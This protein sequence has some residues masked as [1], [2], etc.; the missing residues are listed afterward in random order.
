MKRLY[1]VAVLLLFLSGFIVSCGGDDHAIIYPQFYTGVEGT[2]LSWTDNSDASHSFT[3]VRVDG[4]TGDVTTIGGFGF[5]PAMAYAPDGTL[6]G[7]SDELRIIDPVDGST[8]RIGDLQ[9]PGG[10]PILMHGAAF[11]PS[12][13]LYVV[14]NAM[15]SRVFTVDL[16]TAELTY[17]G[18]PSALIWDIQFASNG[19]SYGAFAD[20][21]ILNPVDMSTVSDV[22]PIGSEG[23]YVLPLTFD[24]RGQLFGMDIYPSTR[25]S[26]I[27]LSTGQAFSVINTG[28]EGLNSLV[29]E[30][31]PSVAAGVVFSKAAETHGYSSPKPL[32]ALLKS[33]D[34]IKSARKRYL[35]NKP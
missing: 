10:I 26:F 11:S 31:T 5:F 22:G 3:L 19:M 25:I 27:N 32:D 33:A 18:T 16:A 21:F 28:S 15:P 20:L 9:L 8:V 24:S 17:V 29:V 13:V 30:R 35:E 7:I 34:E 4:K 14:E 6:Y 1:R 23:E 2:F 12:G